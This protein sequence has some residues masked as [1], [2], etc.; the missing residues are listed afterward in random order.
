MIKQVFFKLD[1]QDA[2]VVGES[3]AYTNVSHHIYYSIKGDY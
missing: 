3:K 2:C 1:V